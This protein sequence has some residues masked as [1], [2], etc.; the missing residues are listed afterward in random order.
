[1]TDVDGYRGWW[2]WLRRFEVDGGFAPGSTWTCT[3]QP[4]L[5]WSVR[6]TLTLDEIEAHR[7]VTAAVSGDIEGTARIDVVDVVGEGA[8]LRLRSELAPTNPLLRQVARFA[9][10]LVRFGHDWVLDTGAAQFR[11]HAL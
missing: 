5:P 8:E 1:M 6:F 2:P 10:P 7:L 4:P 11:R 9:G 3:V